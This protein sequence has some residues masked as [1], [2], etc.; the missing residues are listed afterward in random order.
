MKAVVFGGSGFLGSHVVDELFTR[1]YEVIVYDIN[2]SLYL[3]PEYKM[4]R[5]SILDR[6][7]VEDTIQGTDHVFH[8]AGLADIDDADA[9]PVNTLDVNVKST[10]Y[11]LEACVKHRVKRFMFASTVYV[12][13]QSGSFYRCS[14]QASEIFIENYHKLYGLSY[15]VMRYGSLYG[16][17]AN[18]FNF[19]NNAIH[20]AIIQKKIIR[21]GDGLEVRDY[22]NVLDAAR[23]SVDVVKSSKAADYVMLTGNKTMQVRDILNMIKEM[24]NHEIDIEYIEGENRGHY[25]LTPYNFKPNVA[26]KYALDYYHDLGQGILETI[27]DTYEQLTKEEKAINIDLP[28]SVL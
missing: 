24:L 21:K 3:R 7:L 10:L 27:Y 17:R 19:V 6:K 9:D 8:F 12:Y 13:S 11:I 1:G 28:S 22:I 26:R 14:K 15:T 23:A 25:M 20:S 16:K 5:G 2:D 18:N 4:V